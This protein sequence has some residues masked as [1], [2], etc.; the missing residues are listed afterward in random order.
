[1]VIADVYLRRTFAQPSNTTID[2][3]CII[4][5]G[6]DLTEESPAW[7]SDTPEEKLGVFWA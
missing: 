5:R 3:G 2:K 6:I 7:C 1:M 4:F